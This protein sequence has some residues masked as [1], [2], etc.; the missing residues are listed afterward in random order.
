MSEYLPREGRAGL[1]LARK[2]QRRKTSR[3]N[4]KVGD[5]TFAILRYWDDGFSVDP[6]EASG[7]RG[8]VDVYE[9]ARHLSQCLIVASSEE[10]GEMVYEF[11]RATPH[12]DH[13]PADYEIDA[14]APVALLPRV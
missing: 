5:Q 4:V 13:A 10:A 9:G 1:E 8:L 2:A 6:V 11:K 14:E 12:M 7:L 3:L